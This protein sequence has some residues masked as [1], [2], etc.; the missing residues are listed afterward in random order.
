[1]ANLSR[2]DDSS[3]SKT[4]KTHKESHKEYTLR[5]LADVIGADLRGD[6]DCVIVGIASLNK[7]QSGE[8]SFL[9]GVAHKPY[10]AMTHASAVILNKE[11]AAMTPPGVHALIVKAPYVAY[12]KITALFAELTAATPGV[13]A[14][15]VIGQ[16]C[17]VHSS[18]SIGAHCVLGNNVT[19]GENVVLVANCVVGD[20]AVIGDGSKLYP[21]VSIYHGVRLGKRCTIHSGAVIGSDGFGMAN[22][23]GVWRKIHQLGSVIVGDDVEVGA[24]TTIDRGALEDTII[25]HGVKLDNLIQVGHNVQIGAHTAIAGCVGIAGSA[26]IGKHCMIGGGT[27]INGHISI[28]DGTVVAARSNICHS[29]EKGGVYAA[30]IPAMQH[31]AWWRILKHVLQL[32]NLVDRV[33]KLENKSDDK[34]Q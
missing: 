31:R 33:R 29:T 25:E 27:G 9:D 14:T 13:H 22:D 7:A 18:A 26:K 19:I 32:N 2:S 30:F 15:A 17:V 20:G 1:M 24:N 5:K 4:H 12:A 10:L 21:N 3:K 6:P 16:R 11:N 28:A 34:E 8:I 23:G